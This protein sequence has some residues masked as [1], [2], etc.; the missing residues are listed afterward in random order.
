MLK[1]CA[2]LASTKENI[3]ERIKI[4]CY[5]NRNKKRLFFTS[6]LAKYLNRI[7]KCLPC[8]VFSCIFSQK[9]VQLCIYMRVFKHFYNNTKFTT[10]PIL[11]KAKGRS[12]WL[13]LTYFHSTWLWLKSNKILKHKWLRTREYDNRS[14]SYLSSQIL[15]FAEKLKRFYGLCRTF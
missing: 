12:Q 1:K 3:H 15:G 8:Q 5:K 7:Y 9:S 6:K 11:Q 2:S 10:F 4:M 13:L 14:L